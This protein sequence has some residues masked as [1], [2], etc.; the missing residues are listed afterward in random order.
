MRPPERP[1][2]LDPVLTAHLL[3]CSPCRDVDSALAAVPP[4]GEVDPPSRVWAEILGEVHRCRRVGHRR[5][6]HRAAWRRPRR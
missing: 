5:C 2:T 6:V 4:P 1:R 3:A